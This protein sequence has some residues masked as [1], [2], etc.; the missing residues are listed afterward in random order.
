V[1]YH[2][3]TWRVEK[4]TGA[5]RPNLCQKRVV[6]GWGGGSRAG[7]LGR[8]GYRSSEVTKT[9]KGGGGG[10]DI[11]ELFVKE[12]TSLGTKL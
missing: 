1:T 7:T 6:Y 8:G 11:L 5:S 3:F 2:F 10:K 12:N 9:L 4:E